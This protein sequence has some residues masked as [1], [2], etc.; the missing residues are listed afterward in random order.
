MKNWSEAA[1]S[2]VNSMAIL[3]FLNKDSCFHRSEREETDVSLQEEQ[4]VNS[5]TKEALPSIYSIQ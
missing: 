3:L 4:H 2:K 1:R 5:Q